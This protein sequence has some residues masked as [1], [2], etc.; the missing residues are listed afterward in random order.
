MIIKP[1]QHG[2]KLT[3]KERKMKKSLLTISLAVFTVLAFSNLANAATVT[4]TKPTIKVNTTQE[5]SALSKKMKEIEAKQAE[6]KAKAEADKK[7]AQ[8]KQAQ[9]EK[10]L[11]AKQEEVKKQGEKAK[12]DWLNAKSALKSDVEKA[13]TDVKSQQDSYKASLDK[14]KKD[15][16][17]QSEANEAAAKARQEQRAKAMDDFKNSLKF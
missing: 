11:K 4:Y 10:E 17:A 13:K 6:A 8:E 14:A 7:A 5:E 2:F 9:R 1:N 16:Q 3:S 15:A 12:E